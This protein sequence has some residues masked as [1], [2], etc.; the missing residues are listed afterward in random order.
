VL[1]ALTKSAFYPRARD[2]PNGFPPPARFGWKFEVETE[3]L[4]AQAGTT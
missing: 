2:L 3:D 4:R 1:S